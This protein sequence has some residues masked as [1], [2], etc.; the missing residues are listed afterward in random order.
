MNSHAFGS[1]C[2][3]V[4]INDD[5]SEDA[6]IQ[7]RSQQP[8]QVII[9]GL[10]LSRIHACRLKGLRTEGVSSGRERWLTG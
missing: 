8:I 5:V 2:V 7:P 4:S 3:A 9:A 10:Q 1:G 6:T